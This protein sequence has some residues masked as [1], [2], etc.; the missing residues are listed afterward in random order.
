MKIRGGGKSKTAALI[1]IVQLFESKG[2]KEREDLASESAKWKITGKK[3][4]GRGF[5]EELPCAMNK[6]IFEVPGET[7]VKFRIIFQLFHLLCCLKTEPYGTP[8]P[9]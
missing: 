3:K 1:E 9:I 6:I 7:W 4:D 8:A 5:W 2:V